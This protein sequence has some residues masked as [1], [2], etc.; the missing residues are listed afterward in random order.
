MPT[1]SKNGSTDSSEPP[2]PTTPEPRPTTSLAEALAKLQTMLPTVRKGEKAEVPTKSGGKYTYTY[3]NLADVSEAVLPLLGSVGL[4]WST[5]PTYLMV[6]DPAWIAAQVQ[7]I[8]AQGVTMTPELLGKVAE[9]APL[10]SGEFVLWWVLR[11]AS[12]EYD[13]G[14]V[15]L[16]DPARTDWQQ[17]GSAITYARRYCLGAVT[18][19]V[20]SDDDDAQSVKGT[21][22]AGEQPPPPSGRPWELELAGATTLAEVRQLWNEAKSHGELHPDLKEKLTARGNELA[23]QERAALAAQAAEGSQDSPAESA[24]PPP[25]PGSAEP[26]DNPSTGPANT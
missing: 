25:G 8:T 24:S 9:L 1:A 22:A 19:L 6:P 11:H 4:S 23:E 16:P 18:G 26:D 13:E 17:V 3:A 10:V 2:T 15:P 5:K 14:F 20:V 21:P 7:A 12:G